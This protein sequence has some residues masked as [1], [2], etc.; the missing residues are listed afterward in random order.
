MRK[1]RTLI[2]IAVL[3]IVIVAVVLTRCGKAKAKNPADASAAATMHTV[4]YGNIDS[5][6]EI[7]GELQ[8]ET[9]VAIKSRVSGKIVKFYVDENDFVTS[10]Q[11]IAD[12][13]PDYV[14]ANTLFN[15][16]ATLQLAE[17][18]LAKARKDHQDNQVLLANNYISQSDFDHG[19]DALKN[20]EIQF[21]QAS[22]QYEMIRDLDV[23]GKVTHVFATASGTVIER[24]VN[25]G[26]MVSSSINS[27]GEGTVVMRIADLN[28][29]IVKS[30]INEV[31]IAKFKLKQQGTIKL[32]ALPYE[33]F[34]GEIVKI[35]PMAITENNAK[36]FPV[37]ISINATG[38]QVK[39]GM[40]AA[41]SILGD[42]REHVIVVPI[43][44]VFAD[45]NNQDIVYL[46]PKPAAKAPSA[47]KSDQTK[48][49]E[50]KKAM[51]PK[52]A[53]PEL[54]ATVVKLGANDFQM[55]EVIS[56]L[57]EGDVISLKE[58]SSGVKAGMMMY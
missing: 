34:S 4:A 43:G 49:P 8:P 30:N 17:I 44:A 18:T 55:V 41:V 38:K 54:V 50:E 26:E 58:P 51:G 35:A 23:P 5:K 10:G 56:G 36:V 9:V 2:I 6:I 39:P 40:T 11:I 16:K 48:K 47:E 53:E 22:R 15:T 37:E 24:S 12:I 45:E 20:A 27:Y 25:E 13:E 42:T 1:K 57:A 28:R 33:E 46:I 31:D 7:T 21:E 52:A 14:Q 32:D 29:M 19:Q 3:L